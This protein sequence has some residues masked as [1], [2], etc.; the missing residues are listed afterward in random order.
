[1]KSRQALLVVMLLCA[2][3][4]NLRAGKPPEQSEAEKIREKLM[5]VYSYN[6]PKAPKFS[7]VDKQFATKDKYSDKTFSTRDYGGSKEFGSKDYSTK[8][9]GDSG[10]SWF[11]KLFP[12]K[13]LP[14][15]LQG[16]SRDASKSFETGRFATKDFDASGKASSYAGKEGYATKEISLKGKTQGAIDNN[17]KLQDAVR[18]GLSVDDVRN[19]LNKP[20]S[21]SP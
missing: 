11:S 12:S 5:S 13:K 21:S 19:L 8:T 20:G 7:L 4:T 14:Q 16:T 18:K 15:N 10:K 6:D 1:M 3:G 2:A 17:P 9:Y